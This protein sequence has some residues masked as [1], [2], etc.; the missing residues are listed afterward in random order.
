MDGF[1]NVNV[2]NVVIEKDNTTQQ[3]IKLEENEPPV[4]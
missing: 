2:E 1:R 3:N 4:Q